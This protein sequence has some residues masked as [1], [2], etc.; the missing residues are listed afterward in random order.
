MT[1]NVKSSLKKSS[2]LNS[3]CVTSLTERFRAKPLVL[4]IA[5]VTAWVGEAVVIPCWALSDGL[6]YFKWL[7]WLPTNSSPPGIYRILREGSG[8]VGIE[9]AAM[10]SGAVEFVGVRLLLRN[11]SSE[12]RGRYSCVAGNAFG[13]TVKDTH[14]TVLEKKGQIVCM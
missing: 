7:H 13:F 10:R 8:G 14:V 4:P 5:N 1:T 6:P 3:A 12:Q 2:T 11:V 9:P